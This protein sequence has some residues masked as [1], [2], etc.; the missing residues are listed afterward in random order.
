MNSIER[1]AFV[2][3]LECVYCEVAKSF[4]FY[5]PRLLHTRVTSC[6]LSLSFLLS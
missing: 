4:M 2:M 6:Q 1:F 5:W 3:E